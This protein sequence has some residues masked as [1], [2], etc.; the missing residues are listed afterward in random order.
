MPLLNRGVEDPQQ[1]PSGMTPN[2]NQEEALNKNAFRAP[3]RSGFTLIELLVVVLI[4][5]VL[6]AIALPQYQ[7]AVAK[8][9]YAQ[10]QALGDALIKSYKLYVLETGNED[11]TTFEGFINLPGTLAN[12]KMS[13]SA[14]D[15]KCQFFPPYKSFLCTSQKDN[16]PQ[17]LYNWPVSTQEGFRSCVARG[18]H[19][20]MKKKV[21][22]ANGGKFLGGFTGYAS[23]S[24][25]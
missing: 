4:I 12:N 25:P 1:K 11:P 8:A 13:F 18:D 10:A 17:W 16:A 22:L 21:C 24:L 9:N 19:F 20:E 6:A 5:A 23:Y 3:L 2:F 14:G 7:L 15:W